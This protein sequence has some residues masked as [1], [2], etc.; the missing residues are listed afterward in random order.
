MNQSDKFWQINKI[1]FGIS[2]SDD[3]KALFTHMVHPNPANRA[4]L[5]DVLASPWF[6]NEEVATL[7]DA[8]N[9]F[10]SRKL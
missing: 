5:A 8:R 6:N 1:K 10:A 3:F 4:S 7:E 9:L 2:L